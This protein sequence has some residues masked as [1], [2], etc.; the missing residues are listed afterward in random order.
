[1]RA[2]LISDRLWCEVD[3]R[4]SSIHHHHKFTTLIVYLATGDAGLR[5]GEKW[6]LSGGGDGVALPHHVV[7]VSAAAVPPLGGL[8][9]LRP[10]VLLCEVDPLPLYLSFS[11]P[12]PLIPFL[13]CLLVRQC[14]SASIR[15]VEGDAM[16]SYTPTVCLCWSHFSGRNLSR[17]SSLC[18]VQPLLPSVQSGPGNF[19]GS[20]VVDLGRSL[21]LQTN[22]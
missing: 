2:L 14:V 3:T 21:L 7:L 4:H 16:R 5:Y 18:F 11:S 17:S 15:L 19:S 20:T 10:S 6:G 22:T 1:M 13:V 12:S 8:V 9:D